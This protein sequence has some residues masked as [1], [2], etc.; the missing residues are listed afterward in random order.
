MA[1]VFSTPRPVPNRRVPTLAGVAVVVLALPIFLV[2]GFPIGGWVLA[3]TLWAAGEAL[4]YWLSRLPT[5]ADHL[6]ISGL[7]AIAMAFR[8]I[9]VMVALLAVTVADK[10]LGVSAVV[11]YALAYSLALGVSLLEYFSGE[12]IGLK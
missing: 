8:G 9:G 2:G 6:G 5:G 1:G 10:S 4:S 7:V 12:R 3:A 11:V